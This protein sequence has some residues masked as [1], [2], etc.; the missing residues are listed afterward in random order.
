MCIAAVC[1]CVN[2]I[3]NSIASM[4]LRQQKRKASGVFVD[5]E[6]SR[7]TLLL[8]IEPNGSMSAFEFW[9]L[10]VR[11][12]IL[13]GGVFLVPVRA[14]GE[15]VRFDQIAAAK[16]G[17]NRS[18]HTY[19][20]TDPDQGYHSTVIHERNI[21]FLRG[22]SADGLKGE[23]ICGYAAETI[24]L[25]AAGDAESMKRIEN[26]GMPQLLLSED[27]PLVGVGA[28]VEN[29]R[30]SFLRQTE[31]A[32]RKFKRVIFI[33]RGFKATP[34]GYSSVD[35]QLQGMREFAVLD[36][37]RF[38]GVP[39]TYVFADS[40]SNYK[41]AEM[42]GVD[43]LV[44]TLDPILRNIE[45]ELR[46]KLIPMEQWHRSRFEFDRSTRTAADMLSRANYL[47]K[48]AGLGVSPNEIRRMLN[49]EPVEG[50]DIPTISANLR[51]VNAPAPGDKAGAPEPADNNPDNINNQTNG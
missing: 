43:F 15:I 8:S 10:A 20:V 9:R 25:V 30:S 16:V 45:N 40:A 28:K 13:H 32:I 39:P 6:K 7:L 41:S 29:A 31:N 48:L 35:M 5:D 47:T 51:P 2:I 26:G 37:C 38:F 42:S 33:G 19:T 23:S 49:L 14:D 4:P 27:S 17:Y 24:R 21:I 44:N 34:T 50:G 18:D 11:R 3:S 36:I 22:M 12:M 46:R 1:R